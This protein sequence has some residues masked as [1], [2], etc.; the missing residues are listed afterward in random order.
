MKGADWRLAAC[1]L[2]VLAVAQPAGAVT[3]LG[4]GVLGNGGTPSQGSAA[5]GKVLTGTTGQAMVGTSSNAKNNL[6]HGFWCWGGVRVVSV[7]DGPPG[8]RRPTQLEFGLPATNPSPGRVALELSLPSA[9]D[10]RVDVFDL[11]GRVVGSMHAGR[12]DP[13]VYR[14]VW[15]GSDGDGRVS[16]AGV[17]FTR[18][19][20]D[21]RLIRTR[22]FV[23]LR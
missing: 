4:G 18:L 16:G 1:A 17:F 5:G 6:C 15:D 7:E 14:L 3:V 10:V 22:R 12:L 9:A 20:V 23:M 13:G 2:L 11:Q 19:L 8:G 21:G